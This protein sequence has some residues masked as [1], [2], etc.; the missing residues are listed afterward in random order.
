VHPFVIGELALGNL[1]QREIV[2]DSLS[3]LPMS[4][5]PQMQKS[6][7]LSIVMHSS[8]AVSDMSTPTGPPRYNGLGKRS[9]RRTTGGCTALPFNWAW[10]P[11]SRR[12]AKA[13]QFIA[14]FKC[15]D[16]STRC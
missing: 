3:D 6:C 12:L 8:G 15:Y 9:Y 16:R 13:F 10:R 7:I 5:S 4:A 2:L 1:P 11:P 14:R